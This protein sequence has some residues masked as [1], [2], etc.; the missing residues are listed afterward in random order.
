MDG[1]WARERGGRLAVGTCPN[2][3]VHFRRSTPPRCAA[4][5]REG[6]GAERTG[7]MD[8]ADQRAILSSPIPRGGNTAIGQARRTCW[9]SVLRSACA[10]KG[11]A[12]R[13][14]VP[15]IVHCFILPENLI[16]YVQLYPHN[17]GAQWVCAQ[18]ML[19]C[20]RREEEVRRRELG[21]SPGRSG[22]P[23]A[24]GYPQFVAKAAR[25]AKRC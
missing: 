22:S 16:L 17:V 9:A 2:V 19:H 7:S 5:M 15:T 3:G 1:H 25:R 18:S 23:P 24:E 14:N 4:R 8:A 11:T 6:G 21:R 10:S 13:G 12:K 20:P